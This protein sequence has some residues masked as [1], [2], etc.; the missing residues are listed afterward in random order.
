MPASCEERVTLE[1]PTTASVYDGGR[2]L[3]EWGEVAR[4]KARKITSRTLVR[5][6]FHDRLSGFLL[7]ENKVASFRANLLLESFDDDDISA[8]G[9][10][11][12][13]DRLK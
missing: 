10:L 8:D 9:F 12:L 2:E 1:D 6:R 11:L 13:R 4:R 3:G 7:N 5:E